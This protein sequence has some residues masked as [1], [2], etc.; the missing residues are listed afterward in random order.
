MIAII[1]AMGQL[2]IDFGHP[3]RAVSNINKLSI[4]IGKDPKL[5]RRKIYLVTMLNLYNGLA[6]ICIRNSPLLI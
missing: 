6:W 1:R 2:K 3:D 5:L 4:P